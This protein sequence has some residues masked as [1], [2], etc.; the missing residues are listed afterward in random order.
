MLCLKIKQD[1]WIGYPDVFIYLSLACSSTWSNIFLSLANGFTL[2]GMSRN[3]PHCTL[4]CENTCWLSSTGI[5]RDDMWTKTWGKG[6]RECSW[7]GISLWMCLEENEERRKA[8]SRVLAWWVSHLKVLRVEV[9]RIT[10]RRGQL[11]CRWAQH[12]TF[13]FKP[14]LRDERHR[15]HLWSLPNSAALCTNSKPI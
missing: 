10:G 14:R 7:N 2:K 9:R 12:E 11:A 4:K 6:R 1:S 8:V 3:L 15:F 13:T 5:L